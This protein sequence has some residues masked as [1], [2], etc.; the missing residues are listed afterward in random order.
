MELGV[1]LPHGKHVTF[2]EAF[3]G[4]VRFTNVAGAIWTAVEALRLGYSRLA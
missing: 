3:I 2:Q 4:P 1:K